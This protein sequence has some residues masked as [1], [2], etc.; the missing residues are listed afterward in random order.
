MRFGNFVFTEYH[1]IFY[2]IK[3]YMSFSDDTLLARWLSGELSDAERQE[4]EQHPDYPVFR[5]IVEAAGRLQLPDAGSQAMWERLSPGLTS[6]KRIRGGNAP[7]QYWVK[8]AVAAAAAVTLAIFAWTLW[9]NPAP[10]APS[11]VATI[12]GEQKTTTLPDGSTVRLN[13]VSSV[14]IFAGKWKDERRVKLIGEAFFTVQKDA[15]PF[16]VETD[17]GYVS[18]LGTS[19]T[20]RY[21]GGAFEVACYEGVVQAAVPNGA[22]QTLRAT[23]KASARNGVWQPLSSITDSWPG[24]MQGESR[25]NEVPLYEVFAEMQR[26]YNIKIEATG[27]EG[28]RFSGV[29]VHG[30]L[31]TALR[32]V[33]NPMGLTYQVDGKVVRISGR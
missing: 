15:A 21:R 28:R 4:L 5:R 11:I 25:F 3:L 17:G 31:P 20:V 24:W 22:K 27:T 9:W 29:F 19:F 7:R 13:A 26:Q 8:W 18:V 1:A 12:T 32:M 16:I 10:A 6:K 33:C 30:D 14:E 23:Q 2:Q